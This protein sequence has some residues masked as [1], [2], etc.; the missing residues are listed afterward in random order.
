M[1][2]TWRIYQEHPVMVIH[3][4]L[5]AFGQEKFHEELNRHLGEEAVSLWLDLSK[6]NFI[7]HNAIAMLIKLKKD[8]ESSQCQLG[9][10]ALSDIVSL[11][12]ELTH[13]KAAL[14]ESYYQAPYIIHKNPNPSEIHLQRKLLF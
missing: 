1:Y 3:G 6:V 13:S 8:L 4:R 10:L 7:D 9:F 5:D 2:I 14:V 12:L 11:T